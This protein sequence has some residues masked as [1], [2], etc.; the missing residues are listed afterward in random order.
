MQAAAPPDRPAPPAAARRPA[1]P[2]RRRAWGAGL[3]LAGVV[4]F[5]A[6]F[7]LFALSAGWSFLL[8]F[9]A[10][11]LVGIGWLM[12]AVLAPGGT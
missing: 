9:A 8:F 5:A 4:A 11:P 6:S 12:L 10:L 2:E 3:L 1:A 7:G